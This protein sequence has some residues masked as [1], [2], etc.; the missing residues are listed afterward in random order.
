MET[1]CFNTIE[2]GKK[3]K[4][5]SDFESITMSNTHLIDYLNQDRK[6]V[7]YENLDIQETFMDYIVGY[8]HDPAIS[9][10]YNNIKNKNYVVNDTDMN[11]NTAYFE[12]KTIDP[13]SK[14]EIRK[15]LMPIRLKW[16]TLKLNINV[17]ENVL[18]PGLMMSF[19]PSEYNVFK[20][21]LSELKFIIPDNISIRFR[22][23]KVDQS[24][25]NQSDV[26]YTLPNLSSEFDTEYTVGKVVSYTGANV[27]LKMKES[28][29][30]RIFDK[31]KI[32][33]RNCEKKYGTTN[34]D[35]H[36][37]ICLHNE[38]N[39][40]GKNFTCYLYKLRNNSLFEDTNNDMVHI[41]IYFGIWAKKEIRNKP[42]L[43]KTVKEEIFGA[44]TKKVLSSIK[45]QTGIDTNKKEI[46]DS[47]KS[48]SDL[49]KF[50]VG[51]KKP[52]LYRTFHEAFK[53]IVVKEYPKFVK[54]GVFRR[55]I[56]LGGYI[57][58]WFIDNPENFEEVSNA[59]KSNIFYNRVLKIDKIYTVDDF[60][61][62]SREEQIIFFSFFFHEASDMLILSI[63]SNKLKDFMDIYKSV[64]TVIG[65]D[66]VTS[67]FGQ[68]IDL[69]EMSVETSQF[70][71]KMS[72][73]FGIKEFIISKFLTPRGYTRIS[74][75]IMLSIFNNKRDIPEL[76]MAYN[77]SAKGVSDI[78][79]YYLLDAMS[80][81]EKLTSKFGIEANLVHD[82]N[83]H[84]TRELYLRAQ[85]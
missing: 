4:Y 14:K 44:I 16:T 46:I 53:M 48:Y 57:N 35:M 25:S 82:L 42:I 71:L 26:E 81:D 36:E 31:Y 60:N 63:I 24:D 74:T 1:W 23:T 29:K 72:L 43:Q 69:V 33:C 70:L 56:I 77:L 20:T 2:T 75:N 11:I 58:L 59:V 37:Y 55:F 28:L 83:L 78:N 7:I 79:F 50:M 12:S 8:K 27:F 84:T 19:L 10:L 3:C 85:L 67:L 76:E 73:L 52:S 13:S 66:M 34:D 45:N 22:D 21:R 62:L 32:A 18:L 65:L 54:N 17:S 61:K 49:A 6:Y 64:S 80:R 38:G 68:S 40:D 30:G 47:I 5:C 51:S 9:S 15:K 41:F 39:I